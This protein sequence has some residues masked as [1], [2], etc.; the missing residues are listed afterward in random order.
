LFQHYINQDNRINVLYSNLSYYTDLKHAENITWSVKTDDFFPYGSDR[1]DYWSGFFTSRPALKR[2][3]RVSNLLL[4]QVRQVDAIYQSHHT[5]ELDALERAVGLVQHHDGLSGTEKQSVSDDYSLRLN[6]GIIQAEKGLNEVLF[7]IGEKEPYHLCLLANTSVC[8]VST[9]NQVRSS[10][11][12]QF[13][14]HTDP[15]TT[16]VDLAGFRGA[17]SQCASSQDN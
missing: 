12:R 6:D 16:A 9:Q 13:H 10:R 17:C 14:A 4:Q 8:D 3:A 5:A 2:F 15:M 7:V 1:N 11:V